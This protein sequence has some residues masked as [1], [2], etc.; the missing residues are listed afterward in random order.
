MF[1]I[2]SLDVS[3]FIQRKGEFS[4]YIA[5][6]FFSNFYDSCL[7]LISFMTELEMNINLS[8]VL[9][10]IDIDLVKGECHL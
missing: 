4:L 2:S 9:S 6:T 1:F 3:T 8:Y 10:L 5:V 7:M